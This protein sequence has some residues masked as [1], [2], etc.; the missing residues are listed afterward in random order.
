MMEKGGSKKEVVMK[1]YKNINYMNI[2]SYADC[3]YVKCDSCKTIIIGDK[4][5][6]TIDKANSKGWMYDNEEKN[7]LCDKCYEN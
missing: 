3:W 6:N 2:N 4:V 5:F 1:R 7:V